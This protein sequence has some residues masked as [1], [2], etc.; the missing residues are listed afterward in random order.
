VVR[1]VAVGRCAR[2]LLVRVVVAAAAVAGGL[3]RAA[4]AAGADVDGGHEQP[5]EER[6]ERDE[7]RSP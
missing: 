4:V 2:G 5:R 6:H 7:R 1:I 3:L